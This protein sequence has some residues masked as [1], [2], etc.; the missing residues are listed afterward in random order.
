VGVG[1][2]AVRG[3]YLDSSAILFGIVYHSSCFTV[4]YGETN[5]EYAI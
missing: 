1:C 3:I 4:E 5:L 2:S